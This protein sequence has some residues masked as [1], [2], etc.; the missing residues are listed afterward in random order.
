MNMTYPS[1]PRQ[2][3]KNWRI[4]IKKNSYPEFLLWIFRAKIYEA[5]K[6]IKPKSSYLTVRQKFQVQPDE[7]E[8]EKKTFILPGFTIFDAWKYSLT[9]TRLRELT[10]SI[11]IARIEFQ[12]SIIFCVIC[13]RI[14]F[15]HII[16]ACLFVRQWLRS[17]VMYC[18]FSMC[19]CSSKCQR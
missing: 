11:S 1:S 2:L 3:S 4:C 13:W 16:W 17:A 8:L 18:S 10:F 7:H 14:I 19:C 15:V 12:G 5:P 6:G 9:F